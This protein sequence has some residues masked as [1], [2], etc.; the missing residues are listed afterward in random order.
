MITTIRSKLQGLGFRI[1]MGILLLFIAIVWV[2][3]P[4][5][6]IAQQFTSDWIMDINGKKILTQDF[7]RKYRLA[8]QQ[9]QMIKQ[10]YGPNADYF[11]QSQGIPTDPQE[12]AFNELTAE[13]LLNQVACGI[14]INIS[15]EY[16]QQKLKDRMFIQGSGLS[17][18]LPVDLI[19]QDGTIDPTLL[20]Y[21]LQKVNLSVAQFEELLEQALERFMV[22]ELVGLAT[23]VPTFQVKDFFKQR[24]AHKKYSILIWSLDRM[25][26]KEK[27]TPVTDE[28]LQ[29]FYSEQTAQHKRYWVPEK[30][31]GFSWIFKP[32]AYGI[33]ISDEEVQRH[34]DRNKSSFVERP[35]QVQVR[36]IL[37]KID[38]ETGEQARY[39]VAQRVEQELKQ[40]PTQ[41]E[42]L[43][44]EYS[45]DKATASRGG[46]MD[47]FSKG[48][49]HKQFEQSAFLLKK[50]GD[51][52]NI[53]KS[54]DGFEI[55]QRVNKKPVVYKPLASAAHDIKQKLLAE[56][57]KRQLTADI[58][59]L[60][61]KP[62]KEQ[63]ETFVKQ[64]NAVK[65]EAISPMADE[66]SAIA[67]ALFT[68]KLDEVT[69]VSDQDQGLLVQLTETQKKY[70]PALDQIKSEVANDF[71]AAR[72]LKA[73]QEQIEQ[74][75]KQAGTESFEHIK[76]QY[77]LNLKH[78][79]LVDLVDDKAVEKLKD[80]GIPAGYFAALEKVGG[81]LE[82]QD[83]T[84]GYLIRLDEQEPLDDQV[85][86]EKESAIKAD[87]YRE[88]IRRYVEGFVASLH[89]N[90]TID[91]NESIIAKLKDR[92][93]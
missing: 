17:Q 60:S 24:Y 54:N 65:K 53:F 41:F 57:F 76:Q 4:I 61:R 45:D 89:R 64:H 14:P 85:Y 73:Q 63:L 86:L 38:D 44:K 40:D 93:S 43:A 27:Q 21:Y 16:I 82:Y 68:L 70:L 36:R 46:L 20:R 50:D 55:I 39:Q 78:T 34:Y 29:Q 59:R 13:E 33:T 2:M 92:A 32:E 74:A 90:A 11:L 6:K 77:D 25:I 87:L 3:P 12:I 47:P 71:Y 58:G 84:H 66:G 75:R 5:P 42:G 15:S 30:R 88:E 31:A 72:A 7:L 10:Q 35:V 51:V 37:F 26:E 52:S 19:G 79:G 22:A 18:L 23:Y 9:L 48:D 83:G 91:L 69:S 49:H 62:S 56:A 28:E 1:A 67:R 8:E 81:M 80:T